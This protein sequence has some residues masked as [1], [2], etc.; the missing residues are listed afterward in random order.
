MMTLKKVETVSVYGKDEVPCEDRASNLFVKIRLSILD[1]PFRKLKCFEKT[2]GI[3][4]N[5]ELVTHVYDIFLSY[6]TCMNV[7]RVILSL[8]HLFLA[9][10]SRDQIVS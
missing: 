10:D 6:S 4:S 5:F 9:Q 2:S 3:R 8:R 1:L 7:F